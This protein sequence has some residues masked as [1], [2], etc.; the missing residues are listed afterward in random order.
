MF[1]T[2]LSP[3][4]ILS[5]PLH[6]SHFTPNEN[7]CIRMMLKDLSVVSHFTNPF[8]SS[9]IRFH[10]SV[11]CCLCFSLLVSS[12]ISN[13]NDNIF[14]RFSSI[15]LFLFHTLLVF[16][17]GLSYWNLKL[18]VQKTKLYNFFD[19]IIFYLLTWVYEQHGSFRE[20][21]A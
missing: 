21:G 15:L 10:T 6:I 9:L 13:V 7:M 20:N 19:L 8:I 18:W 5:L 11:S 14:L 2:F 1:Y 4:F 3:H 17:S 16:K 12:F